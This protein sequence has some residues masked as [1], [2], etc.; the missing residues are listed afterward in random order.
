MMQNQPQQTSNVAPQYEYA[1]N[2]DTQINA[3]RKG[4]ILEAANTPQQTQGLGTI[5]QQVVQ[6][7]AQVSQVAQLTNSFLTPLQNGANPDEVVKQAV[8]SGVP[9]EVAVNAMR[10]A[11]SSLQG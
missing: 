4:L 1:P 2:P 10:Q 5:P 6:Q 3:Q 11:I 8:Q 7:Q 9:S